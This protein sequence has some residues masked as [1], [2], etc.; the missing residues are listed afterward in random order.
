MLAP[1]EDLQIVIPN[2]VAASK[3][4]C[5]YNSS[6]QRGSADSD[7]K[8]GRSFKTIVFCSMLAPREDLQIVTPNA[9]AASRTIVF[10]SILAPIEDLQDSDSKCGRSFKTIVFYSIPTLREDLQ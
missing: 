2:A 9:I 1:R 10:Y 6:S 5:F 3:P 7:S 4:L 8:C